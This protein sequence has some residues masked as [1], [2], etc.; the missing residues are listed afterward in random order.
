MKEKDYTI[1]D[2]RLAEFWFNSGS[3]CMEEIIK[4]VDRYNEE[5]NFN[6]YNSEE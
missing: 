6:L 1:S 3:K 4:S 2:E 5:Y